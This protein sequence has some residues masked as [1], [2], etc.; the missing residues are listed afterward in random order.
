MEESILGEDLD[1]SKDEDEAVVVVVA[2]WTEGA[3]SKENKDTFGSGFIAEANRNELSGLGDDSGVCIWKVVDEKGVLRSRLGDG[4]G[5]C[6]W[7]EVDEKGLLRLGGGTLGSNQ[8]IGEEDW[9]SEG[10]VES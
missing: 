7:K 4:S 10:E 6:I 1:D 9:D 8:G 2:A 5:V 3:K